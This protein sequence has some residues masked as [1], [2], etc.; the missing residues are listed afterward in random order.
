MKARGIAD[1]SSRML[2]ISELLIIQGFPATYQL[3]GTQTAQKKFI[4]NA[5]VP[6]VVE[7]CVEALARVLVNQL[8][9]A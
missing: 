4:G 2:T 6:I 5:V 3:T 7:S 9:A 8:L 1:I